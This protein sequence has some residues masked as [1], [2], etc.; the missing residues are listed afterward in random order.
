MRTNPT[1]LCLAAAIL[2]VLSAIPERPRAE[3]LILH[4]GHLPGAADGAD[5]ITP[6]TIARERATG[7]GPVHYVVP[8][9][10][11]LDPAL[12]DWLYEAWAAERA[13]RELHE[14]DVIEL[15]YPAYP[16]AP[17]IFYLE[18][19]TTGIPLYLT[20]GAP[21]QAGGNLLR[22]PAPEAACSQ[23]AY[24]AARI[25]QRY[26]GFKRVYKGQVWTGFHRLYSGPRY[27]TG[28]Y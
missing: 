12:R 5:I 11:R 16:P 6:A 24:N 10:H 3:V 4:P 25:Y 7:T 20:A 26:L 2:A 14:I 28:D 22:V 27:L 9:H 21:F 1:T 18:P 23:R 17:V 19:C 8:Q 13:A 15:E